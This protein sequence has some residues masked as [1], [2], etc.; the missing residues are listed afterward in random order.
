MCSNNRQKRGDFKK[1]LNS[2]TGDW[3]GRDKIWNI[4]QAT[5]RS[6]RHS[7][8]SFKLKANP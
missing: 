6:E 4:K 7:T 2:L 8:T 1:T 3:Y 5:T